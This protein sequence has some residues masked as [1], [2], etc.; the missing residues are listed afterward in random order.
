MHAD[1]DNKGDSSATIMYIVQRLTPTSV[2]DLSV[3]LLSPH[4]FLKDLELIIIV[5]KTNTV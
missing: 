3:A 2:L 1:V 5:I 4:A